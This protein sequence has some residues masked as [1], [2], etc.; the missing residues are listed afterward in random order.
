MRSRRDALLLILCAGLAPAATVRADGD[1]FFVQ[2][3]G[4][5]PILQ[6]KGRVRDAAGNPLGG[7]SIFVEV[8]HPRV[9]VNTKS[10]ED[11]GY[12]YPD[13]GLYLDQM[14]GGEVDISQLQMRAV[15][16]GYK[17]EYIKVPE[18]QAGLVE[19]DIVMKPES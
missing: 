9:F 19:L 1:D 7:V 14:A 6:Y 5:P 2:D 18:K 15:K 8:K 13:V 16:A 12:K 10:F 17:T 4:G 11:G 3:D